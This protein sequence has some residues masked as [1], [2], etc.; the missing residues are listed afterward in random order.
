[1]GK[2]KPISKEEARDISRMIALA[3]AWKS[4]QKISKKKSARVKK[5]KLGKFKYTPE[6][7][8]DLVLRYKRSGVSLRMF[9]RLNKIPAETL[10][11]WV[12]GKYKVSPVHHAVTKKKTAKK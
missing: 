10:R 2:I 1:M 7:R 12:I 3:S 5:A 9:A 8:L 4:K 6:Q 11:C